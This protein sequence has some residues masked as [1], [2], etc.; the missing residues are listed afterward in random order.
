[1]H[2]FRNIAISLILSATLISCTNGY[3]PDQQAAI[4]I[5]QKALSE[6][7]TAENYKLIR[8]LHLT[9][10]LQNSVWNVTGPLTQLDSQDTS[11]ASKKYTGTIYVQIDQ[12][13]GRVIAQGITTP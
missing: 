1:M 10:Q 6:R 3:V 9:A 7:Y 4:G 2:S 5:A 8:Q 12:D 13:T 11:G